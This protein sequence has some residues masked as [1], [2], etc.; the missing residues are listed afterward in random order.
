[1]GKTFHMTRHFVTDRSDDGLPA[2]LHD[3]AYVL[4]AAHE[5]IAGDERA[6]L[7][8]QVADTVRFDHAQVS[9]LDRVRVT[10]TPVDM[11][12]DHAL[13]ALREVRVTHCCPDAVIATNDVH[14]FLVNPKHLTAVSGLSNLSRMSAHRVH[15][16]RRSWLFECVDVG[17]E[18]AV[19]VRPQQVV[20]GTCS[21][22]NFDS[23]DVSL[24]T[25]VLTIA[26]QGLV[27]VQRSMLSGC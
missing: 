20:R 4:S 26:L 17:Y 1:M 21:R 14:E 22:V 3:V 16:C 23:I 27:A 8:A 6:D 24:R 2:V 12:F 11:T 7:A 13:L 10:G 25:G 15:D 5:A 18:L 9:W 19:F